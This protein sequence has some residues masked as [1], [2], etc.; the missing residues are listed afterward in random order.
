MEVKM[1]SK[2]I[3]QLFDLSGKT[4]I[5]TGG[6]MGIGRSI[7]E[8]LSEAGAAVVIADID[9]EHGE[10]TKQELS[11]QGRKIEFINTNIS[12]VVDIEKAIEFTIKKFGSIDIW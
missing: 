8:R 12:K 4:A 7:V 1:S 2:T 9:Q 6:S 10:Q 5:V 11:Q 3:P